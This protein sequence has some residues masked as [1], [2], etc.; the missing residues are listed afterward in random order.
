MRRPSGEK[1]G[2]ASLASE[3]G[4]RFTRPVP[5]L[6]IFQMSTSTASEANGGPT[7]NAS[8]WPSLDHEGPQAESGPR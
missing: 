7:M 4:V 5:S 6:R 2:R 8:H 1:S 3:S